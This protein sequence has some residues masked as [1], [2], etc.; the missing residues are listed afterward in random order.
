[1]NK[2]GNKNKTEQPSIAVNRKAR[3]DYFL[4][5]KFEAGIC[6]LGHEVKSIREGKVNL[7]DSF[8]RLIKGEPFLFNCHI[9]PYSKI[10]GHIVD[11]VATRTRKLLLHKAE[12]GKLEELT[13]QKGLTVVPT[14][15]Y[16]KHGLIKVQIAVAKGKKQ[17][18]KR[19]DIKRRMH[20]RESAAAI[21][22]NTRK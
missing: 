9:S 20:D 19:E 12:V 16:F 14:E 6:L 1:M 11:L 21:K 2:P 17:Y 10:Q 4:L 5:E 7:K 22:S 3:H 18:D 15:M 8:V 13:T